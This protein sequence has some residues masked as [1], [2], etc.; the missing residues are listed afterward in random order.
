M[1]LFWKTKLSNL[2]V[3]FL[4]EDWSNIL[5]KKVQV[6]TVAVNFL[7]PSQQLKK[8]RTYILKFQRKIMQD[9]SLVQVLQA[10][11]LRT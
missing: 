9:V 10:T 8:D 6:K 5:S 7:K 4:V 3:I 11:S 2:P 1:D